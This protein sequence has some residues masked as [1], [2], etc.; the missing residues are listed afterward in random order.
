MQTTPN[1]RK[2]T[3]SFRFT[4]L[5]LFRSD[6]DDKNVVDKHVTVIKITKLNYSWII[7]P[8]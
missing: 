2:L 4:F 5:F 8:N 1:K 6:I 3:E 7:K